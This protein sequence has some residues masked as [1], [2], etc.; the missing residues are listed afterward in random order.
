MT[1]DYLQGTYTTYKK[2]TGAIANWLATTAKRCGFSP[3]VLKDSEKTPKLK[4]RA[5]KLARD[6]ASKDGTK[7]TPLRIY[8]IPIKSFTQL[9]SQIVSSSTPAIKVPAVLVTILDRAIAFRKEHNASFKNIKLATETSS[10]IDSHAHFIFVLERRATENKARNQN[11]FE[12]LEVEELS[13]KF[14]NA[15]LS[16]N[17]SKHNSRTAERIR[18]QAESMNKA[19]EHIIAGFILINSIH[20]IRKHIKGLWEAYINKDIDLHATAIS[21]NTAI[22]IVRHLQE[23]HD[24]SF[25]EQP[26]FQACVVPCFITT[27]RLLNV[28]VLKREQPTDLYNF[29]AYD[30][31]N[32]FFV[33]TWFMLDQLRGWRVTDKIA[34]VDHLVP[35]CRDTSTEWSHK[36]IRDKILDDK[37]MLFRAFTGLTAMATMDRW[38]E[39]EFVRGVRDMSPDKPI[40]LWLAFAAQ[41][42]LDVQHTLGA[43]LGRAYQEMQKGGE[44]LKSTLDQTVAFHE[45]LSSNPLN[46][47]FCKQIRDHMHTTG[48][49]IDFMLISDLVVWRINGNNI[50]RLPSFDFFQ[51]YPVMCGLYLFGGR[52]T[53]QRSSISCVKDWTVVI[54]CAHLYNALKVQH[55][56]GR[57]EDMIFMGAAPQSIAGCVKCFNLCRG[58]S[59][60]NSASDRADNGGKKL[61]INPNNRRNVEDHI[62]FASLIAGRYMCYD[63]VSLATDLTAVEAKIKASRAEQLRDSSTSSVDMETKTAN[64]STSKAVKTGSE[65]A[66]TVTDLLDGMAA[67]VHSEG[68]HLTFDYLRLHRTCCTILTTLEAEIS[69]KFDGRHPYAAPNGIHRLHMPD[70]VGCI[71]MQAEQMETHCQHVYRDDAQYTGETLRGVAGT[72]NEIVGGKAGSIGVEIIKKTFGY[73]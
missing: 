28:D 15:S 5:R 43:E 10:D 67:A 30:I 51:H 12:A 47:T 21:T 48:E 6:A 7:S 32:G 3:E 71:L 55:L 31:A 69:Y 23:D 46:P 41:V 36:S 64:G 14:L 34:Y 38:V 62:P 44:Y 27:C 45:K 37:F 54:Y 73:E 4:G 16:E 63:N 20:K 25:H 19:D 2:D 40:P 61:K 39:D 50:K 9:A 18:Y 33:N 66:L 24:K 8:T 72:F 60:T 35:K 11:A 59:I 56:T 26:D 49:L 58:L 1:P 29:D 52:Y 57:W 13:D 17:V 68:M 65:H 53:M 22:E 70:L 42:Y